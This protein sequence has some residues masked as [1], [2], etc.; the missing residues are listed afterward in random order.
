MWN[1]GMPRSLEPKTA[2]IVQSKQ[3][4]CFGADGISVLLTGDWLALGHLDKEENWVQPN[5][6]KEKWA[7]T[8]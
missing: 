3:W 5:E 7:K 2:G 4:N 8:N 1:F 6:E